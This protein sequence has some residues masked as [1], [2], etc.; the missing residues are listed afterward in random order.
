MRMPIDAVAR[1]RTRL[2]NQRSLT[3]RFVARD[4]ASS[5]GIGRVDVVALMRELG[6][7]V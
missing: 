2:T 7:I 5:P 3:R 6:R 1:L 4:W